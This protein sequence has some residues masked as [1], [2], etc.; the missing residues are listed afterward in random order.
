M[1]ETR[2]VLHKRSASKAWH[3]AVRVNSEDPDLQRKGRV[4]AVILTV[5]A[6]GA[7]L[8]SAFNVLQGQRQYTVQNVIFFLLVAILFALTKTGRVTFAGL[9]TVVLIT[10]SALFLLAE[11][12]TLVTTHVVMCIPILIAS[13]LLAPWSG[14]VIAALLISGTAYTGVA[15]ADYP[16]LLALAVV[17]LIAYAFSHS[18]NQAYTQ[19]RH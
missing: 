9:L 8:L 19:T 7:V 10:V 18:L 5:V 6:V 17:A 12:A 16:A 3:A 1:K 4:L 11:D 13:F 14:F 2:D 15:P